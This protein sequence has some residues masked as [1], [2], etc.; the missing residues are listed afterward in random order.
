MQARATFIAGLVVGAIA[1][2]GA[3]WLVQ[4]GELDTAKPD[5]H[6]LA[7]MALQASAELAVER[8]LT[9]TALHGNDPP[10]TQSL[11]AIVARRARVDAR[12]NGLLEALQNDGGLEVSEPLGRQFAQL[13]EARAKVDANL[14]KPLPKRERLLARQWFSAATGVL[15]GLGTLT[16]G[17]QDELG[18]ET[19]ATRLLQ[20]ETYALSM[21]E[22]AGRERAILAVAIKSER[23]FDAHQSRILRWLRFHLASDWQRVSVLVEAF[24]DE[25]KLQEAAEGVRQA[26]FTELWELATEIHEASFAQKAYP[27]SASAWFDRSSLAIDKLVELGNTAAEIGARQAPS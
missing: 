23:P 20:I 12:I 6:R 16:R 3:V 22:A 18:Q 17:F 13:N 11:E 14:A 4:P 10:D 8:G 27:L 19:A 2:A 9:F 21:S 5:V 25:T 7:G 26:Y 15:E 1:G 24:P